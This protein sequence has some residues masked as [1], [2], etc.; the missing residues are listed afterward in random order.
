MWR[1]KAISLRRQC[2]MHVN[3]HGIQLWGAGISFDTQT[4]EGKSGA[5]RV[6]LHFL[7]SLLS[8]NYFTFNVLI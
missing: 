5:Y 3:M 7:K 4:C 8:F 6:Q 1:R 2:R